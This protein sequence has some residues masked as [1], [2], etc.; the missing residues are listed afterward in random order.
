MENWINLKKSVTSNICEN[1]VT[2]ELNL[3]KCELKFIDNSYLDSF[4]EFIISKINS[5]HPN[6]KDDEFDILLKAL[7]HEFIFNNVDNS[8]YYDFVNILNSNVN[9]N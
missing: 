4:R 9:N 2:K 8:K 7:W 1:N 3:G 6:K 5:F